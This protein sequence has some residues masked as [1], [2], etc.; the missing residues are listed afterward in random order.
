VANPPL[1]FGEFVG[2]RCRPQLYHPLDEVPDVVEDGG[3]VFVNL[4]RFC[5]MLEADKGRDQGRVQR[6]A[7]AGLGWGP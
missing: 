3:R 4:E 5:N 6:S 1:E 2:S 7:Q